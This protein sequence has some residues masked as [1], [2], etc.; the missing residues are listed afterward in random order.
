MDSNGQNRRDAEQPK[1]TPIHI[2]GRKTQA[3]RKQL[4]IAGAELHLAD[5]TLDRHLPEAVKQ[6][7]VAHALAQQES[8]EDKVQAAAEELSAVKGLLEIEADERA[9][10]ERELAEL[11]R[12]AA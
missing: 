5:V 2:A 6:G 7:E 1:V 10:L 11:R 8:V 3:I 12:K 9:R 4:E